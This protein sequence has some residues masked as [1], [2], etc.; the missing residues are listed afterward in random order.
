[1][2][3]LLS[4]L[5]LCSACAFGQRR[6]DVDNV[7]MQSGAFFQTVNGTPV[8]TNVYYRVVDGSAFLKK[9]G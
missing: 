2:K 8:H 9:N 5:V 3:A 1:M 7:T 6:V 4:L